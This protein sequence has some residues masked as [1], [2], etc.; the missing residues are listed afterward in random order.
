YEHN[1]ALSIL[2]VCSL[3][4]EKETSNRARR[5]IEEAARQ[6]QLRANLLRSISC[7]LVRRTEKGRL[8]RRGWGLRW[9][10]AQKGGKGT[11]LR[12]FFED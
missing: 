10:K 3:A 9:E 11:N 5:E 4:L 2:D 7:N 8:R 12:G 6:E 1:L